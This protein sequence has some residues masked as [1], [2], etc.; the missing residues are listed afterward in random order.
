MSSTVA[1]GE[2]VDPR[3]HL[4]NPRVRVDNTPYND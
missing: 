1:R 3:V 4:L 2:Q